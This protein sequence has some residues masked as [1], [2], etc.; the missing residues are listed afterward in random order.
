MG[1]A[2]NYIN[3]D[4][5]R[6]SSGLFWVFGS[7]RDNVTDIFDKIILRREMTEFVM[8]RAE[9]DEGR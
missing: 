2:R 9:T 6:R 4:V 3:F 7:V 1:H 8:S 5:L